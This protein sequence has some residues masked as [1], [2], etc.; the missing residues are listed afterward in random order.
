MRNQGAVLRPVCYGSCLVW[1]RTLGKQGRFQ[2]SPGRTPRASGIPCIIRCLGPKKWW[3][4]SSAPRPWRSEPPAQPSR[5]TYGFPKTRRRRCRSDSCISDVQ[6]V[7]GKTLNKSG[8]HGPPALIGHAGLNRL[9]IV[10]IRPP[11]AQSLRPV[12]TN[13]DIGVCFV[14]RRW[15]TP[16]CPGRRL[17]LVGPAHAPGDKISRIRGANTFGS[18]MVRPFLMFSIWL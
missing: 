16:E 7:S 5:A 10:P 12:A 9:T 3:A 6:V 15:T 11:S 8:F 4:T 13:I 1:R 17:P 18:K 14:D 2:S